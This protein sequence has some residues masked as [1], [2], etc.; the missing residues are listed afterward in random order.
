M[1]RFVGGPITALTAQYPIEIFFCALLDRDSTYTAHRTGDGG[2][3]VMVVVQGVS[4]SPEWTDPAGTAI[5]AVC[6][7]W[8]PLIS[9]KC[10]TLGFNFQ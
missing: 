9:Q 5:C 8:E 3:E 4:W 10:D 6:D 2:T 1:P 7:C